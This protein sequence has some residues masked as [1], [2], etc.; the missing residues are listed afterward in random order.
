[1]AVPAT[2]T[3]YLARQFLFGVMGAFIA[4]TCIVFMVEF[5]EMLRKAADNQYVGLATVLELVFLKMPT[6]M[7][8]LLPFATLFGTIWVFARMTQSQELVV[9]RAAGISVWQFLAPALVIAFVIGAV[10]VAIVNPLA[11]VMI[12]RYEQLEGRYLEAR[13]SQ[14]AVSRSGLWL[15]EA[16]LHGQ[17][18]VHA[19]SVSYFGMHLQSVIIFLYDKKGIFTQRIDAKEAQLRKGYWSLNKV[20]LL[21]PDEPIQRFSNYK[22]PTSLT[23]DDIQESFASPETMSFWS[24]PRFI[25][26][27]EAAGFSGIRHRLHWHTTLALPL[28][29]CAMVLLAATFSMRQAR[30]GGTGILI[31]LGLMVGLGLHFLSDVVLA[32]GLAGTLPVALAAWTPTGV[33]LLVSLAMMLHLEEG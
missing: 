33:F 22:V 26:T 3:L 21:R 9:A 20:V 23:F 1:M 27:L 10:T 18:V 29:M 28:L 16:G 25:E 4:F 6:T 5:V 15:R 7:Q 13:P 17:A 19:A 31:V 32:F 24:L 30:R 8:K 2:F 11:A 14:L 12:T